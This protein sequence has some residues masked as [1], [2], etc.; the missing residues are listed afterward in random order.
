MDEDEYDALTEEEKLVFDREVQQAL[1]ERKK[2]WALLSRSSSQETRPCA[3]GGGG[4]SGRSG[5][6]LEVQGRSLP[7]PGVDGRH[8]FVS[9]LAL[10]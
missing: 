10:T 1:K 3:G 6:S 9:P 7:L 8:Q 2:R 4:G 5:M